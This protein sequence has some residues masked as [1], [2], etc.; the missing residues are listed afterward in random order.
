MFK[1]SSSAFAAALSSDEWLMLA[2]DCGMDLVRA[3]ELFFSEP[4]L[5]ETTRDCSSP[6]KIYAELIAEETGVMFTTISRW[7]HPKRRIKKKVRVNKSNRSFSCQMSLFYKLLIFWISHAI[8]SHSAWYPTKKSTL[9]LLKSFIRQSA[10]TKPKPIIT[11]VRIRT[12][13]NII[14][15]LILLAVVKVLI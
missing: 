5:S 1:L 13:P 2:S 6:E 8:I 15:A 7:L 10:V 4:I 12:I 3:E 11:E 9:I 14:R